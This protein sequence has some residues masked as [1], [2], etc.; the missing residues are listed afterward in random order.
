MQRPSLI[1]KNEQQNYCLKT[2]ESTNTNFGNPPLPSFYVDIIN[3][4]LMG[5]MH[6]TKERWFLFY[7]IF[8]IVES[9]DIH[10]Y[11]TAD[12]CGDHFFL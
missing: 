6:N 12:I 1:N 11:K 8:E 9:Y 2:A 5:Q 4:M 3:V 7:E 10:I